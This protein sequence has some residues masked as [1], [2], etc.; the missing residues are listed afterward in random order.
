MYFTNTIGST[1]FNIPEGTGSPAPD[2]SIYIDYENTTS[3]AFTLNS[4]LTET[5]EII[6]TYA[7]KFGASAINPIDNT[8][9][10]PNHQLRAGDVLL[11]SP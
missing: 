9:T 7:H 2:G 6:G 1:T 3:K 4:Q 10:W 5:K 11:F 8:I